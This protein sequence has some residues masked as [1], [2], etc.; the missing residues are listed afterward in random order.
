MG[1][2]RTENS[3]SGVIHY[4][5]EQVNLEVQSQPGGSPHLLILVN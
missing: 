4:L 2:M 1:E 5:P 3:C